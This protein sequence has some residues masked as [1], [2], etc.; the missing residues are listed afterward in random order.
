MQTLRRIPTA[1]GGLRAPSHQ[2][3]WNCDDLLSSGL[4]L[5]LPMPRPSRLSCSRIHFSVMCIYWDIYA[6][7]SF[8]ILAL[9]AMKTYK[10][11][12]PKQY[13]SCL[14]SFFFDYAFL[15]Y[16][17]ETMNL[18]RWCCGEIDCLKEQGSSKTCGFYTVSGVINEGWVPERKVKAPY[19]LLLSRL[20]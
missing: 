7:S 11:L 3:S 17:F 1:G 9:G 14:M 18:R 20:L 10:S 19:L 2:E 13:L 12:G 8:K 6:T 15:E 5:L 16:G 4:L